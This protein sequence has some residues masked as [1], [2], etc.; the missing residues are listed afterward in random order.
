MFSTPFTF[1]KASA[2][3]DAT[4]YLAAVVAA[5]G[6]VDATIT[7]ATNTLFTDLKANSLYSKIFAM[8]PMLG[9]NAGGCKFNA[10]DPRDLDAAYRIQFNGGWTFSS[11]GATPNGTTGYGNTYLVPASVT[12]DNNLHLSYYSLTNSASPNSSTTM[13]C[14]GSGDYARIIIRRPGDIGYN[15]FGSSTKGLQT[16]TITNSLGYFLGSAVTDNNTRN[17]YRNGVLLTPT[18]EVGLGIVGNPI[19]NIYIGANNGL[20]VPDDFD[21]K[22]CA[23]STIGA[24]LTTGEIETLSTIVNTFATTLGRNTY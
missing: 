11:S 21:N 8:Y 3:P 14:D 17:F 13:G 15:I 19:Y 24:G 12:T 7:S 20:D 5:G 9:G 18:A 22:E 1:L 23:F 16:Y 10:K 4:A 6:T 2:D